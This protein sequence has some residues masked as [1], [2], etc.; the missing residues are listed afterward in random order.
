M[1]E[2]KIRGNNGLFQLETNFYFT[3]LLSKKYIKFNYNKNLFRI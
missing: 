3:I 1:N 2:V